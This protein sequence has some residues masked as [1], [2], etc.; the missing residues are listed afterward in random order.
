MEQRRHVSLNFT[1]TPNPTDGKD[2][3]GEEVEWQQELV[4]QEY[5]LSKKVNVNVLFSIPGGQ[6]VTR[7]AYLLIQE[8]IYFFFI[9]LEFL[10][11]FL[12]GDCLFNRSALGATGWGWYWL[13]VDWNI[14]WLSHLSVCLMSLAQLQHS[15]LQRWESYADVTA[16]ISTSCSQKRGYFK[17]L[18][19]ES[20]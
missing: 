3:E 1:L 13:V 9:T 12:Q 11:P 7:P 20:D 4:Q 19:F 16:S 2:K 5:W 14:N 15:V 18:C 10:W 17:H 6:R 8:T